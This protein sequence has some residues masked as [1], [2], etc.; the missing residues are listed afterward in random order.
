[1]KRERVLEL[2]D[3]WLWWFGVLRDI[4]RELGEEVR[5]SDVWGR[6]V[7]GRDEGSCLGVV[8]ALAVAVRH[9]VKPVRNLFNCVGWCDEKDYEAMGSLFELMGVEVYPDVRYEM[10]LADGYR[11]MVLD[12]LVSLAGKVGVDVGKW[13]DWCVKVFDPVDCVYSA[14]SVLALRDIKREIGGGR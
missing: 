5:F 13:L 1:M 12:G 4:V 8:M 9:E 2:V 11:T 10:A 6:C 3:R 14:E 7:Q